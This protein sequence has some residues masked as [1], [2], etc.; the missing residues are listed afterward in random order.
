MVV[1]N[2]E[3]TAAS[4]K[5]IRTRLKEWFKGVA[6]RSLLDVEKGLLQEELPN[7]FGY[8]ILQLGTLG[9]E[10]L[11]EASR[12]SHRVLFDIVPQDSISPGRLVCSSSH[13]PI[14]ANSVDV[15]LLPHV[16]EFEEKPH[17]ILREIERTLIGEGHLIILGFN[18]LSLWGIWHAILA[19]RDS[20]PWNGY[21]YRSAR[22]RDWLGLLGFDVIK[23]RYLFFRPPVRSN[24]IMNRL[25]FLEKL[26]N[27][28]WPWFGGAYLIIGKKRLMPLTPTKAEWRIRRSLIASGVAEPTTRAREMFMRN[29]FNKNTQEKNNND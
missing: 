27:Y 29:M 26:G 12:I 4:K 21:Y 11:L 13:L 17:E 16:L 19:W 3:T 10:S 25:G 1:D 20:P 23:T 18:P 9:E 14:D 8:H 2:S 6:G 22:I 15:I 7:L 28:L 24:W 5:A